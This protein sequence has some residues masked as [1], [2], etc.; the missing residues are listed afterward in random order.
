MIVSSTELYAI[1][2]PPGAHS[3][4]HRRHRLREPE[5]E[6]RPSAVNQKVDVH[7]R[8]GL[9]GDQ[10]C[11]I[12][13]PNVQN[14]MLKEEVVQAIK[15]GKFHIW[16]VRTI[17]EGIEVLTA[18]PAGVRKEDG[19]FEEGTINDLVQKRL[20]EMAEAVKAFHL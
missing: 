5:G 4:E 7:E 9:T 11:M 10:G 15:D 6:S 19:T 2:R 3:T 17:D 20:Q 16:P 18:R 8:V 13:Y 14:L 1:L 12:P